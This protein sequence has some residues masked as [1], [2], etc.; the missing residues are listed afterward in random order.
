MLGII[1][2]NYNQSEK[3]I[4]CIESI[5]N[6]SKQNYKIY[7]LDN[8]SLDESKEVLKQRY[9]EDTKVELIFAEKNL[10]Y[11]RGN[12]LCLRKAQIDKCEYVLISNND[13]IYKENAIDILYQTLRE[14]QDYFIVAPKVLKPDNTIQK[15]VKKIQPSFWQYMK[16]E[17]YASNIFKTNPSAV[18]TNE[19]QEVYWVSGCC[20]MAKMDKFQ[21]I[22]F[23]DEYTFLYYE[24]YILSQKA[25]QKGFK[26]LYHP[27]SEILH[28]HGASTNGGRSINARIENFRSEI[29]FWKKYRKLNR[30]GLSILFWMRNLEVLWTSMKQKNKEDRKKYYQETKKIFKQTRKMGEEK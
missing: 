10:G 25:K 21:E 26:I 15:S 24:E 23:F 6:T 2:I 13:I 19:K 28:Y 12:N 20:F 18:I 1:I 3:T 4:K 9:E 8:H 5:A 14:K 17:T 30:I 29:Y 22:N 27:E 7:L 16:Y 11:A